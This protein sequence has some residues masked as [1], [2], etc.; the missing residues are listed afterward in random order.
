MEA[1]YGFEDEV[2]SNALDAQVSRLR[3]RL[4][5]AGASVQIRPIRGVGYMLSEL[6]AS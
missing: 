1:V 3:A 6:E 4:A 2:Q 5:E